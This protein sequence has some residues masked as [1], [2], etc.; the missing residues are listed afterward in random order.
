MFPTLHWLLLE[1]ERKSEV[2]DKIQRQRQGQS[3]Q[4]FPICLWE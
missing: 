4:C 1:G 3:M 2:T